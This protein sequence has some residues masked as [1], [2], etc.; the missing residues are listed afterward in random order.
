MTHKS[1]VVAPSNIALIKYW[2]TRDRDSTLPFNRSLSMTL[3]TCTTRTT[4]E[5]NLDAAE[6][7]VEVGRQAGSL[8]QAGASFARP[9]IEHLDRLRSWAGVDCRFRV[10]TENSFPMGAGIASSASGFAALALA[11]AAALGREISSAT[12]SVLARESG[13]GSAA[14]SVLGGFVEWPGEDSDDSAARQILP[15]SH[16]DLRDVIAILDSGQKEVSSRA[17]HELAETSPY[18]ETRLGQLPE[19]LS[20]VREALVERDFERLAPVVEYEAIDLHLI[21]MSSRPPIF[22]WLPSSLAVLARVRALRDEGLAVCATMDAGPN[23][24]LIC[25][26]AAEPRVVD[27]IESLPDVESVIRDGVGEGPRRSDRHLF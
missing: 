14:R 16:W 12:A 6:D 3:E 22:Y 1:T 17:G 5:A 4:V 24:H 13:S 23:V 18:F 9:V 20:K 7:R 27:A 21:A 25:T 26:A 2:G 19:R 10:A 8:A 15:A 11:V